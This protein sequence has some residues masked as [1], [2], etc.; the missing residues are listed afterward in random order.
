MISISCKINV[1][2]SDWKD[3]EHSLCLFHDI[4]KG[5]CLEQLHKVGPLFKV[6]IFSGSFGAEV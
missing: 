1:S 2:L 3:E 5:H 6:H 4:F